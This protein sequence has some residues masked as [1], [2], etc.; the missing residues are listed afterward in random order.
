[1]QVCSTFTFEIGTLGIYLMYMCVCMSAHVCVGIYM[2]HICMQVYGS[3]CACVCVCVLYTR[4]CGNM[5]I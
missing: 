2:H 5:H 1:M 4:L 3:M